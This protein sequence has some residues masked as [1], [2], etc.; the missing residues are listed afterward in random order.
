MPSGCSSR[1]FGV[2]LVN[3]VAW[4]GLARQGLV[5][6]IVPGYVADV[7]YL[8]TVARLRRPL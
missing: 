6:T 2:C 7:L 5:P 3:L 1:A 8:V 4:L